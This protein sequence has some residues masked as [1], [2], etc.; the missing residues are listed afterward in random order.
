MSDP[1]TR[2]RQAIA[3]DHR[4]HV[5]GHLGQLLGGIGLLLLGAAAMIVVVWLAFATVCAVPF[6]ADGT[7]CYDRGAWG[8]C[9][10]VA[11]PPR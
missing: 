11:E 1:M 9:L 10:K 5:G 6:D 8:Q 4:A 2:P 3:E 7:R